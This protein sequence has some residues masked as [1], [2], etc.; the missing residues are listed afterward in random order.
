MI[1][2]YQFG[3]TFYMKEKVYILIKNNVYLYNA[4]FKF[5]RSI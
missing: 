1:K 5:K 4:I 3:M 2:S